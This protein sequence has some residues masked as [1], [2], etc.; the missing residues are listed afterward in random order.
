M[1][2]QRRQPAEKHRPKEEAATRS[3]LACTQVQGRTLK[4]LI[5]SNSVRD[6]RHYPRMD[7]DGLCVF[8]L[9]LTTRAGLRW[10]GNS[11]PMLRKY[12][13]LRRAR[14]L[15]LWFGAYDADG[16]WQNEL[17]DA[18][19]RYRGRARA[20]NSVARPAVA[21]L[22]PDPEDTTATA[23]T[24]TTSGASARQCRCPR[25]GPDDSSATGCCEPR[26]GARERRPSF[27]CLQRAG[28]PRA[29]R[30]YSNVFC[31]LIACAWAHMHTAE[32]RDEIHAVRAQVGLA[33]WNAA[34]VFLQGHRVLRHPLVV[35][36]T[37]TSISTHSQERLVGLHIDLV[38]SSPPIQMLLARCHAVMKCTAIS[39]RAVVK[40]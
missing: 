19:T 14:S 4:N 5:I 24:G 15:L 9:R 36:K 11:P 37:S 33:I 27:P 31:P 6:A 2:S 13:A 30:T 34:V 39:H 12:A 17:V 21:S 22:P 28:A 3:R 18:P 29:Y 38:V 25:A 40:S 23:A 1:H 20:R 32:L 8:V 26:A 35:W 10:L 16:R 7:A